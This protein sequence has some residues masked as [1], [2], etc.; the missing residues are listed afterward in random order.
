MIYRTSLLFR[1]LL[2]GVG[3][4]ALVSAPPLAAHNGPVHKGMA[5]RVYMIMVK[6][7]RAR[8][9][10]RTLGT[11]PSGVSAAEWTAFQDAMVAAKP[12][13][14][15]LKGIPTADPSIEPTL[16]KHQATIAGLG[17]AAAGP[18]DNIDDTH[19]FVKPASIGGLG[20]LQK[21]GDDILENAVA[22]A[23]IPFVCLG[24]CFASFFGIGG[25]DT[26]KSC[27]KASKNIADKVP[28]PS[29]LANLLP[30]LGDVTDGTFTGLWHFVNVSSSPLVENQYDDRQGMLYEVAGPFQA[31]GGIDVA[32]MAGADLTGLSINPEKSLGVQNYEITDP[33]DKFADG[34]LYQGSVD[35]SDA[36]WQQYPM[37]H[38]PFAPADNLA[39]HGWRKFR[40]AGG[41]VADLG[42]PLHALGD[43]T[44]PMHVTGATGW[45]HRPYEDAYSELWQEGAFQTAI[46]DEQILQIGMKYRKEIL[47]WRQAGHPGDTPVRHMVRAVAKKTIAYAEAKL[48]LT[49]GQTPGKPWPYN[50]QA[51]TLWHTVSEAGAIAIYKTRPDAVTLAAPLMAEGL[52]AQLAFLTSATESGG[53]AARSAPSRLASAGEPPAF[54]PSERLQGERR[55]RPQRD[56]T[57]SDPAA[58]A[59]AA[60]VRV[61]YARLA[62]LL[63]AGQITPDTY[64]GRVRDRTRK[65]KLAQRDPAFARAFIRGDA[66]GDLIP[67]DR[68]ASPRTPPLAPTDDSGRRVAEPPAKPDPRR[69]AG[70]SDRDM[71]RI[72]ASMNMM[73][74]PECVSQ[75]APSKPRLLRLGYSN[76]TRDLMFGV[77]P[78]GLATAKCP[79]FYEFSVRLTKVFPGNASFLPAEAFKQVV[80]RS[81]QNADLNPGGQNRLIFRVLR[82]A[83]QTGDRD[84]LLQHVG[85]YGQAEW[86][87]RA[88][89]ANGMSS[90]WSDWTIGAEPISYEE[91]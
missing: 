91:P 75:P 19:L 23:L 8:A 73:I 80:Y 29:D 85:R 45:G 71:A 66:D 78:A 47:Q 12:R 46:S 11:P 65:A 57:R 15:A 84:F 58:N 21:V 43:A 87:A 63:I 49:I 88:I 16:A 32:I 69:P 82:N 7:E 67:D 25:S 55:R 74:A 13:L 31:P 36:A 72:F 41:S 27:V 42:Y 70:P 62:Q 54:I 17:A 83:P 77:V 34:D 18:D 9:S 1:S 26:C 39:L 64:V 35:R 48:N 20:G 51:S 24:T 2:G 53:S 90:N 4:A 10:G 81:D 22:V 76:A 52:G 79:V 59:F 40:A 37:G 50:D 6:V 14:D 38:T 86:R 56:G 33:N 89:N 5:E 61:D 44:V 60:A 68:D 30:G 3:A 28:T